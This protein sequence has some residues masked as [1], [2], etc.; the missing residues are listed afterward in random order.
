MQMFVQTEETPNQNALKF[1]PGNI[2]ISKEK[3][4]DFANVEAAQGVSDL[5]V[6]LFQIDGVMRVFYGNNFI[7]ITKKEE[8]DWIVIKPH[9]FATIVEYMT[10]GWPIFTDEDSKIAHARNAPVMNGEIDPKLKEIM[11]NKPDLESPIIKEIIALIDERIRPAVAMDG[12]DINFVNLIDGVVYVEMLGA[13]SG[14]SSSSATLKGG[15]E[16]LLKHYIPEVK[17]VEAI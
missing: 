13:C 4:H 5:A 6:K 2:P 11:E 17:S 14:C 10:N 7:T 15:V 3:P 8:L 9:I 16:N 12:G 1:V